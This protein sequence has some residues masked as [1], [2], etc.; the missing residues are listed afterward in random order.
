MVE[1]A[2]AILSNNYH[3]QA[4]SFNAKQLIAEQ[5]SQET[6]YARFKEGLITTYPELAKHFDTI[7]T[8]ERLNNEHRDNRPHLHLANQS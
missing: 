6:V 2:H 7:D 1:H 8:E 3:A 5:F 4:L